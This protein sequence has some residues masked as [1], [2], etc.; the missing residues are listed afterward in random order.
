MNV[1]FANLQGKWKLGGFQAAAFASILK[2]H[3]YQIYPQFSLLRKDAL[4]LESEKTTH[5]VG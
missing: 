4:G 1:Q 3:E 5:Q 2:A